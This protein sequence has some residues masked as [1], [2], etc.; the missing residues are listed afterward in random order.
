MRFEHQDEIEVT[1]IGNACVWRPETVRS[2]YEL[3]VL[4]WTEAGVEPTQMAALAP[5]VGRNYGSFRQKRRFVEKAGF[6]NVESVAFGRLPVGLPHGCTRWELQA[7]IICGLNLFVC[8]CIPSLVGSAANLISDNAQKLIS[9][10]RCRYAYMLYQRMVYSP[11]SY[12]YGLCVHVD[13]DWRPDELRYNIQHWNPRME[14]RGPVI[15]GE[16]L[17]SIYPDWNPRM[18]TLAPLIAA[19]ILRNI[20]PENY[21]S[22]PHLDARLG[23]TRTTLREWIE[24]DPARRG[25]LERF[26]DILTKWT[27]PVEKIPEIRE[28]LYR[29]GRVFYWRFIRPGFRNAQGGMTP[30]PLFRPDLSAPWEAPEPIPE[31]YRADYW[32]DK[33]SGLTY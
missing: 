26:S 15:A 25:T 4:S 16:F 12:G 10:S 11:S 7:D 1:W 23:K 28:E 24:A 32:K 19:G 2:A 9:L 17:R 20:F 13:D 27:P 6:E 3:V 5:G 33:D 14:S 8:G 21:L 30:E 18:A 22:Q 29:A 31:I